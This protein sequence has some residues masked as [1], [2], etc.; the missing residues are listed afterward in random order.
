MLGLVLKQFIVMC[1]T[2]QNKLY[3]FHFL[4]KEINMLMH[5]SMKQEEKAQKELI[6]PID[7][8]CLD[9]RTEAPWLQLISTRFG[10]ETSSIKS[11]RKTPPV[12]TVKSL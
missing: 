6:L 10:A 7:F 1:S 12:S 4:V 9:L 2:L 3:F 5:D 8:R 11:P